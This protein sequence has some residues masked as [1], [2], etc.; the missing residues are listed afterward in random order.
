MSLKL[1]ETF[2]VAA[3]PERVWAF[4][5]DPAQVVACLPGAELLE[6]VDA[7]TYKGRV[8][9]KVGPVS[10]SYAGQARLS[11]VDAGSRQ[12]QLVGEGTEAGGAGSARMEMTGRV[13]AVEGGT[14]VT[15]AATIDIAGK[16]MQFGRGLVESVSRQLFRQFAE[17]VR[18][19]LE[20]QASPAAAAPREEGQADVPA[21][22]PPAPR[23]NE[24]RLL[25]LL[26]RAL[27]DFVRRFAGRSR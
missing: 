19:T 16:V 7:T 10:T 20:A 14:E 4:L 18:A 5:I 24:W 15:V 2:R 3:P 1:N 13:A 22:A 11:E 23:V 12:M 27:L 25:P 8:R 6:T 21:A 17:S 9:V 26:W